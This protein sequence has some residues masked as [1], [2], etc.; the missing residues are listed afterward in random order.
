MEDDKKE[1][2]N[3]KRNWA[4]ILAAMPLGIILVAG[5]LGGDYSLMRRAR[6]DT[7]KRNTSAENKPPMKMSSGQDS[8]NAGAVGKTPERKI[9]YWRAPMNPTEIYDKPGKSAMGMDLVPVYE[10]EVSGGGDI[11]IDPVIQQDMG[12]RTAKVTRGILSRTIRAYGHITYDET[13]LADVNLK[14]SGWVET[15]QADYTGKSVEKGEPLF[16][17][18]SPELI[19][20]GEEYL[21]ALKNVRRLSPESSSSTFMASARQRLEYF[22]VPESEINRIA[23]TGKIEKTITIR[24][25]FKGVVIEKH[26]ELGSHIQSGDTIYRIADLSRVWVEAHIYEYEIPWVTVG[27]EAVMTLP[28]QPGKSYTGKVSFIYPYLQ[29]KTRDVV[30]RIE[31]ENPA[32]ALKPDMYADVKIS[33]G[34]NAEGTII[35]SEAV[36]RSGERNVVF[37]AR[38]NNKFTPRDVTL[39][40]PLDGRMVQVLTGLAPGETIVTSAQFMLDSESTLR[41]AVQKMLEAKKT[42]EVKPAPSADDFFKD[43]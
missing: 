27:Q 35:P 11:A 36:I 22:D 28:S 33:V 9:L 31:V 8:G 15:L 16:A 30:V 2:V 38:E 40:L 4:I 21:A 25:P 18:Y 17:L 41:E 39:G 43:M 29:A 24:S 6:A 12:V 34:G 14:F 42:K 13:R 5:M 19:A 7:M 23:D 26:A 3:K 1:K 37:V 10:D 20:V 32:L